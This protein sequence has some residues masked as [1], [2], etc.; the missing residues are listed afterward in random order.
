MD[1]TEHHRQP[2]QTVVTNTNF[3]IPY[4]L[5]AADQPLYQRVGMIPSTGL[6]DRDLNGNGFY[7]WIRE[8][9][10]VDQ[11]LQ[12]TANLVGALVEEDFARK[13]FV[14]QTVPPLIAFEAEGGGG[15]HWAPALV[16]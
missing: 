6:R 5:G 13:V 7:G 15:H 3:L 1:G 4:S 16:V 2:M 9:F 8:I 10:C 14:I 12:G 11:A